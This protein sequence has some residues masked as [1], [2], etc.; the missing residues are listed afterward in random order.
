ML[1]SH[2]VN[3][4]LEYMEQGEISKSLKNIVEEEKLEHKRLGFCPFCFG[5]QLLHNLGISD[6]FWKQKTVKNKK[7]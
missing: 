2:N 3:A 4:Y 5:T 1:V 7:N 6:I